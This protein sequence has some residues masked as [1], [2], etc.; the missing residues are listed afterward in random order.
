MQPSRSE[1]RL[2]FGLFLKDVLQDLAQCL[3]VLLVLSPRQL[4]PHIKGGA[5][6]EGG[7]GDPVGQTPQPPSPGTP[8]GISGPGGSL[9]GLMPRA[10][11]LPRAALVFLSSLGPALCQKGRQEQVLVT[12]P[13]LSLQVLWANVQ[14]T[15]LL[16]PRPF[17]PICRS[18]TTQ[19]PSS[20]RQAPWGLCTP[21]LPSQMHRALVDTERHPVSWAATFSPGPWKRAAG[22]EELLDAVEVVGVQGSC[23]SASPAACVLFLLC[24]TGAAEFP[25]GVLG[26]LDQATAPGSTQQAS[27]G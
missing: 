20:M 12:V 11:S 1:C 22:S 27:W 5:E 14:S 8:S 13:L 4:D 15:Q 3:A 21:P 24:F 18:Q 9:L 19:P 10:L 26:K 2:T 25:A 16:V 23:P 17:P 7:A 6:L